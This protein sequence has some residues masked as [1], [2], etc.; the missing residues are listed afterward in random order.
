MKTIFTFTMIRTF[1][2]MFFATISTL[3]VIGQTTY[4][5]AVA[6]YS[7]SPAQVTIN[8]GDKVV[9]KNNGGTH[10]VNGT[11]ATF[12]SNPE[13]FGNSLGSGWT[14]E[15]TFSTAGTYNYQCDPHAAFGMVGKV[16]V[17]PKSTTATEEL[18]G[19]QDHILLYP[20][21]ASQFI[22]LSI[23]PNY[24]VINSLRIFSITG[25]LIDQKI[26]SGN[27]EAFMYD[28]SKYKNGL[29]FM[30]INAG[31]NKNVLKFVKQ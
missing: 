7:F 18:V 10:N 6:N 28:I 24:E 29:Y 20:N 11:K 2:L 16:I 5:V 23:P 3:N 21:P 26:L 25:A 30:E 17:N 8:I 31:K 9:W 15:Y 12:A 19:N 22:E 27:S 1:V 4:N 14:Y 13:S